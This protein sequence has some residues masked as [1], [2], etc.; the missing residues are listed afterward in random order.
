MGSGPTETTGFRHRTAGAQS[1]ITTTSS[2]QHLVASSNQSINIDQP[3]TRSM[4]HFKVDLAT[5][6]TTEPNDGLGVFLFA[7]LCCVLLKFV[8]VFTPMG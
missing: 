6:R 1:A 8:L 7:A 2:L 4:P 3:H 5:K